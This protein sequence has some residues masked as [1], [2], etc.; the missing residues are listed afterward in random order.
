AASSTPAAVQ[1]ESEREHK[2]PILSLFSIPA[3][4]ADNRLDSVNEFALSDIHDCFV[5]VW[6]TLFERSQSP[7]GPQTKIVVGKFVDWK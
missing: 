4:H 5:Q 3:S 7:W 1:P 6:R 2:Q